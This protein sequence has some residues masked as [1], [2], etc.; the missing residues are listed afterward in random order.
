MYLLPEFREIIDLLVKEDQSGF[1]H[2]QEDLLLPDKVG[3]NSYVHQMVLHINKLCKI[4]S[5]LQLHLFRIL[6][7]V[8]KLRISQFQLFHCINLFTTYS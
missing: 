8:F 2:E 6:L 5:C 4:Y 7:N 3:L 1:H